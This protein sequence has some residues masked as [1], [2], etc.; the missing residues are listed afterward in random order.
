M[1][2]MSLLDQ[3]MQD[4]AEHITNVEEAVDTYV[5]QLPPELVEDTEQLL[6]I[7]HKAM[8]LLV[9]IKLWNEVWPLVIYH[10][11]ETFDRLGDRVL[12]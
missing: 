4:Y 6:A 7:A 1:S 2:T 12:N 8:T 11:L 5:E 10:T 3:G 9:P